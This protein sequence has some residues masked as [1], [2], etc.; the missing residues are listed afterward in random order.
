M[1]INRTLFR[2]T[3]F[4][5]PIC[6]F[7]AVLSLLAAIV[8]FLLAIF[9][10]HGYYYA[11]ISPRLINF[12]Y[13]IGFVFNALFTLGMAN[14]FEAAYRYLEPHYQPDP[15]EDFLDTDDLDDWPRVFL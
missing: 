9:Q 10:D 14:I 5:P 3:Y 13:A 2:L 8:F 4:L 12:F 6:R 15:D 1:K 11:R 7:F